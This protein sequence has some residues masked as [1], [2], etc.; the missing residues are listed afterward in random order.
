M[1]RAPNRLTSLEKG[2]FSKASWA[3]GMKDMREKERK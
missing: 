1:R 3:D 2:Q